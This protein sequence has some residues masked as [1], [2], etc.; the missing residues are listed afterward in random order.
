MHDE[1]DVFEYCLYRRCC[2]ICQDCYNIDR[3]VNGGIN[4]QNYGKKYM[5]N[6]GVTEHV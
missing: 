4:T 3:F 6:T 5:D 2:K 1:K